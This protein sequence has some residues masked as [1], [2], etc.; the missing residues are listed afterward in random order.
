MVGF[1]ISYLTPFPP[2][3]TVHSII[4]KRSQTSTHQ[5]THKFNWHFI[6]V[7]VCWCSWSSRLLN[8]QKVA[9][10]SPAQTILDPLSFFL[11]FFGGYI[12]KIGKRERKEGCGRWKFWVEKDW[13]GKLE[14]RGDA[15]WFFEKM[16]TGGE[17]VGPTA[18]MAWGCWTW[19]CDGEWFRGKWS[20]EE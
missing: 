19:K 18:H 8:T 12:E 14:G 9:G 4:T 15:I 1:D 2:Y 11:C 3:S 6:T 10:S 17:L 16:G 13:T 5:L 20:E 7:L